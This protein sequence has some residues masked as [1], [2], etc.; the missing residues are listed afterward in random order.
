MTIGISNLTFG[1]KTQKLP[2]NEL[3]EIIGLALNL[4]ELQQ[5]F[6]IDSH[7]ERLPIK[8]KEFGEINST[9]LSGIEKFG[10]EILILK[11]EEI[12][13][14]EIPDYLNIADWTL[15]DNLLRLQLNYQIEGITVN[16]MFE[17]TDS[18]WKI[19]S[20]ELWEE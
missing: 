19:K 6:H 18:K 17:R 20:A 15:V 10:T 16:Y 3:R 2:N 12:S 9:N 4:P 8:I 7:P 5:Y 13:R 1:Q 14:K 11:N